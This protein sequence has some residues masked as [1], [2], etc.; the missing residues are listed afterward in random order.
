M[1]TQLL[2]PDLS[3][4]IVKTSSAGDIV[5]SFPVL[6]Y[7]K[8]KFP[9]A[10]I[11]W[12]VESP[13]A[14][15]VLAHP[16]VSN[17]HVADTKKWRR[18]RGLKGFLKFRR[19]IQKMKYDVLFDLQGNLKSGLIGSLAKAKDKVGFGFK[20]VPESVNLLFTRHRFDP[21]PGQ[22]I[23]LDYLSLPQRYFDDT[24]VF[25]EKGVQLGLNQVQQFK[26]ESILQKLHPFQARRIMVCNGAKWPSKCVPYH[27]LLSFLQLVD[28]KYRC[29]FVLTWGNEKE[30]ERAEKLYDHFKDRAILIDKLS[31]P[32]LQNLM[33]HMD[34]VVAM[35]SLPLHLAA[36]TASTSTLGIFGPSSSIKY[37][38]LG[39]HH[40]KVQGICPIGYFFE[41]RCPILRSCT[42]KAC[43]KNL[44]GEKLYHSLEEI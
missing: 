38:P 42:S 7:L 26:L 30:R 3:I 2:T 18:G 44:S 13:F 23:R 19:R 4:L 29:V 37:A 20:S 28:E 10:R 43:I 21:K 39:E 35:D 15:L 5:Q 27:T 17:V 6:E 12:V 25:Q 34:L 32:T 24:E 36:T 16:L 14:E 8:Q 33:E 22:N 11:D 40:L 9:K 1:P 41:K 31:L